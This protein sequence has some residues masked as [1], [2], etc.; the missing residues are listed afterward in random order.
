MLKFEL[1]LPSASATDV[2]SRMLTVTIEGG[3]P[4]NLTLSGTETIVS[5]DLFI[6]N[7]NAAVDVSLADIDDAGNRSV[8][9][10][11]SFVLLDTIAPPQP[12]EIGLRVISEQ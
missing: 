11:Q 7:D 2:T 5:N 9:R 3:E 12:G 1:S 10:D 8:S 6:G 4:I